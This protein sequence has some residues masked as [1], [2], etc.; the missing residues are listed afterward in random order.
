[1]NVLVGN[2]LR[3]KQMTLLTVSS[4]PS[5]PTARPCFPD[6][7]PSFSRLPD[8][9]KVPTAAPLSLHG[10]SANENPGPDQKGKATGILGVCFGQ[11]CFHVAKRAKV[12]SGPVHLKK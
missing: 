1:V 8:G 3:T 11:Q 9:P 10:A 2:C 5:L 6:S 12:L 4:D 7:A